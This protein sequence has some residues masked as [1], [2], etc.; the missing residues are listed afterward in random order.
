VKRLKHPN[1]RAR[2]KHFNLNQQEINK[3]IFACKKYRFI[4]HIVNHLSKVDNTVNDFDTL[5]EI[6]GNPVFY[7]TGDNIWSNYYIIIIKDSSVSSKYLVM[8]YKQYVYN[9]LNICGR[10]T[11]YRR[12]GFIPAMGSSSV[13]DT[14]GT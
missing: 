13:G 9:Y 10:Y 14:S 8:L 7:N 1:Y 12:A 3:I 4:K 6:I 2:F 5:Y 11:I